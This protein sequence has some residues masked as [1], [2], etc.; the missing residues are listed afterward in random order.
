MHRMSKRWQGNV[1][2]WQLMCLLLGAQ[3]LQ[4]LSLMGVLLCLLCFQ[5]V[6][7]TRSTWTYV[8]SSDHKT[9]LPSLPQ[10]I[11]PQRHDF[12]V[13]GQSKMSVEALGV[14]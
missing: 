11:Y 9:Y 8:Q 13:L 5:L 1:L 14:K 2:F 12:S 6:H 3:A 7:F 4:S 10:A